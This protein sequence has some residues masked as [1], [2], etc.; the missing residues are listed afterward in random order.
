MT[1]KDKIEAL[2]QAMRG[3]P[4][5]S[6]LKPIK[7]FF[8]VHKDEYLCMGSLDRPEMVGKKF[9]NEGYENIGKEA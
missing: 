7:A 9:N 2:K 8:M 1:R 3:K 6:L 4:A 5:K